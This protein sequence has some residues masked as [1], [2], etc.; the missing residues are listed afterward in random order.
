MC[1]ISILKK[2]TKKNTAKVHKFIRNGASCNTDGS[3]FMYK[4]DGENLVHVKKGFFNV[5]EMIREL[6]AL[7][8]TENDEL[9]IHHRIGTSGKVC[10]EN[11]HPFI[12]SDDPELVSAVDIATDKP[13]MVHNGMFCH[14]R[15]F[16]SRNQDFSDTYAFAR[17][18]MGNIDILNLYNNSPDF[19]KKLFD[20]V[21]GR[22]K[23]CILFPNKDLETM[24]NFIEDEGYL[25]SNGGYC[26]YVYN[27]GG[28]D[29]YWGEG[30][31][32][33]ANP[34][35]SLQEETNDESEDEEA[36]EADQETP[37]DN[38]LNCRL[39]D[40][41]PKYTK[42]AKAE[43]NPEY[44]ILDSSIITLHNENAEHFAYVEKK[45][46]D[47]TLKKDKHTTIF[48]YVSSFDPEALNTVLYYKLWAKST[49]NYHE[50]VKTEDLLDKYYYVARGTYFSE[51][52]KEYIQLINFNV[53]PT[54]EVIRN[55]EKLL[56]DKD[57]ANKLA[58]DSIFYNKH[59]DIYSKMSLELLVDYYRGKYNKNKSE[60]KALKEN[61]F[62]DIFTIKNIL[63]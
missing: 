5:E 44:V 2:G 15:D 47:N 43:D 23:V 35:H 1:L 60:E 11:T 14:I 25:H 4:K 46:W 16:M 55:L 21:I 49:H 33:E 24:G 38:G 50:A 37:I 63:N 19:F 36:F 42:H 40:T 22:D 10:A 29:Y 59:A 56:K 8:L 17:Y 28:E 45:V 48:R 57:H 7:D 61:P 12:I 9:V 62:K 13:A 34:Q 52:Y 26:R 3:G 54:L 31:G 18:I 51:I 41:L 39:G 6:E 27:R 58:H 32:A 30:F 53:E 20:S